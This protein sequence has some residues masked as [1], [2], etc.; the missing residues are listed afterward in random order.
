M[1]HAYRSAYQ[2]I[3]GVRLAEMKL[4]RETLEPLLPRLRAIGEARI[5]RIVAGAVGIAGAVAVVLLACIGGQKDP[6]YALVGGGAAAMVAY[7]VARGLLALGGRLGRPM[8]AMPKLTGALDVDL[9][10]I[11]AS[12]PLPA[13]HRR[14]DSLELWSTALPL[15]AISLL[16][17]LC[18]HY[19]IATVAGSQ[20]A[21]GFATWIRISL[22]IVGHAHLALLALAIRFAWKMKRSTSEDLGQMATSREWLKAW[23]IT[24]GVSAVPG[25]LLLAVPPIIAA[26]TGIVFIPFMFAFMRRRVMH[27]RATMELAEETV[28]V[29]V[30]SDA[31]PAPL[32]E[33]AWCEVAPAEPE[34]RHPRDA[35]AARV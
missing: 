4:A 21:E 16:M 12:D 24:V 20:S 35:M 10:R 11:E 6:T 31:A 9:A 23:G 13:I 3:V 2:H 7:G 25:V 34:R 29:R 33:A 32:E 26:A 27:E 8:P 19:G 22:V 1:S 5:A 15:G 17:P 28:H 18:L 30:A 14:L